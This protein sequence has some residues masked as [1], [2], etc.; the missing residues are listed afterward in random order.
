VLQELL[1]GALAT[2]AGV[3]YAR[4]A[5]RTRRPFAATN[6][7][8]SRGLGLLCDKHGGVDFVKRHRGGGHVPRFDPAAYAGIRDGDL[9][10][11]R[12]VALPQF[13]REV[14]PGVRARFALV[15]GDD[16]WSIPSDYPGARAILEDPRVARWFTQNYDGTDTSGRVAGIPIGLDFHTISNR[17]K[18]GH[19]PISPAEQERALLALRRRMP[20]TGDREL[21]AH[22]D[23]HF[24]KRKDRVFGETRDQIEA[25]LR[26]NPCVVFQERK[27]P[28]AAL[29]EEKTRYAFVVSP[30]GSG[31]D[32]HRT[33]ESLALGNIV[34]V[35]RSSLDPLYEGL[36]VVIVDDWSEITA[37][38][39]R[40]WRDLHA[41][42]FGSAAVEE[43]LTNRFWIERMRA[44][45]AASR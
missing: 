44:Q 22:A 31:L 10:W 35:R 13:V 21:A 36:P 37:G 18:W 19:W 12:F 30:H 17:R 3:A 1:I 27:V 41:G 25:R 23:F 15:T 20:P 33:W 28:R 24:N 38:N 7:V 8:W 42:S 29:W 40:R 5:A 16:D 39:L 32:C 45:L 34:I 11:V 43:R 9:V 6:L 26:A 4:Y 14:L 2:G